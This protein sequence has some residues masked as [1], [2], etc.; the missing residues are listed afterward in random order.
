METLTREHTFAFLRRQ[1][2][3]QSTI[4]ALRG[5][6]EADTDFGMRQGRARTSCACSVETCR[7]R[8]CWAPIP[9][10][11][12]WTGSRRGLPSIL[13]AWEWIDF[14]D[15]GERSWRGFER[16]GEMDEYEGESSPPGSLGPRSSRRKPAG[17]GVVLEPAA[18]ASKRTWKMLSSSSMKR[19]TR[20]RQGTSPVRLLP[21]PA[22]RSL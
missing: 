20:R 15:W 18:R 12:R 2:G 14:D 13:V 11:G 16:T 8:M 19:W 5:A 6:G 21:D 10:W 22:N 7:H 3:V 1:S 9:V 17:S 4:R